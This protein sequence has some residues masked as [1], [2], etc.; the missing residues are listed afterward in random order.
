MKHHYIPQ[1]LLREWSE[2]TSDKKIEVFRRDLAG[3]PSSRRTPKFTAYEVDLYALSQQG[4]GSIE[5]NA[6]EKQFLRRVDGD[7]AH[8]LQKMKHQSIVNLDQDDRINWARFLMSLRIRQPDIVS[9]LRVEASEGLT[10]ALNTEPERYDEI[11]GVEDPSTLLEWAEV[12]YPGLVENFGMTF[13]HELI[14]NEDIGRKLLSMI[15]AYVDLSSQD[16]DLILSDHPCIFTRGIDDPNLIVAL[17]IG[18]KEAFIAVNSRKNLEF[19]QKQRPKILAARINESSVNQVRA[20][21]YARN[22]SPRR[23]LL[24]RLYPK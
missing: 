7:A 1:F 9:Q 13:F 12:H 8:V 11:A 10:A 22:L 15:W 3:L 18:P 19:F 14:D 17:P 21:A 16:H 5:K 23:F 6:V 24:N 20:R 2:T 4:V